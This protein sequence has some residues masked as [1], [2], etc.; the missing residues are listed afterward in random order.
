MEKNLSS[1]LPTSND[2]VSI[3]E[4]FDRHPMGALLLCLLMA[5]VVLGIWAYRGGA[6][7]AKRTIRGVATRREKPVIN[8]ITS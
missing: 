3:V 5:V 4:A 7:Q 2:L 6:G 1:N 8:Q